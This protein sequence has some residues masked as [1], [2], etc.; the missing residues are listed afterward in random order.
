MLRECQIVALI[1]LIPSLIFTGRPKALKNRKVLLWS[2]LGT[3]ILLLWYISQ[4]I[5]PILYIGQLVLKRNI[6]LFYIPILLLAFV[7][8]KIIKEINSEE[9]PNSYN[10]Y[11]YPILGVGTLICLFS[12]ICGY[13]VLTSVFLLNVSV[14]K[15]GFVDGK[16]NKRYLVVE[17][18]EHNKMVL[19]RWGDLI[20]PEM[21]DQVSEHATIVD[22]HLQ[23]EAD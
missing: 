14:E 16:G 21:F 7:V 23:I 13:N 8:R 12:V 3:S 1:L 22:G 6:I 20:Y 17:D 19:D 11:V 9:T 2:V 15:V 10:R 5:D 18:I 4:Y